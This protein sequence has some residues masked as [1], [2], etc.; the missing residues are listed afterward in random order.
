MTEILRW[1]NG[2]HFSPSPH[3]LHYYVY[4]L[5]FAR[6]F[7]WMNQELEMRERTT[8]Q[9]MAAAHGTPCTIPL[10]K[11]NQYSFGFKKCKQILRKQDTNVWTELIWFQIR[12]SND[13]SRNTLTATIS[14]SGTLLGGVILISHTD[15]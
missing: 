4:L 8:D 10:R 3:Q 14:F 7:W 13:L 12:S 15:K 5:V 2:G 6:E 9:K 1:L 11:S